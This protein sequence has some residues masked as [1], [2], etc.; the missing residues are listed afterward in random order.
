MSEVKRYWYAPNVGF[1][2]LDPQQYQDEH[3]YVHH[4]DYAAVAAQLAALK[5]D[6][7]NGKGLPPMGE[8]VE[9]LQIDEDE[10]RM[11]KVVG[12]DCGLPV[13]RNDRGYVLAYDWRKLLTEEEREAQE[14]EKALQAMNDLVG[15][16]DEVPT[17][18]DALKKLYDAG[19]RLVE[20]VTA[21]H[22]A[23][24]K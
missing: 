24:E 8:V 20:T 17:W 10:W 15:D 7:W 23:E 4:D 12:V 6:P 14:R 13:V 18:S 21:S 19:F 2:K 9:I 16:I 22:R 1:I 11:G 5:A 3:G